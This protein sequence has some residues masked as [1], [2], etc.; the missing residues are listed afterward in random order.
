MEITI[1][2]PSADKYNDF[3]PDYTLKLTF[4][5]LVQPWQLT[6]RSV[7]LNLIPY[8]FSSLVP[9]LRA[10]ADM[11]LIYKPTPITVLGLV[12]KLLSRTPVVVDLD[13]LGA[14]VIRNEGRSRLT[15]GLV[16]WSERF[17][18]RMPTLSS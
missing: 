15:Y 12:P 5:R 6:T 11:V 2:T 13:D 3:K 18:M 14:E 10:R 4:A 8:L 1:I 9:I 17:C 7:M 16:D